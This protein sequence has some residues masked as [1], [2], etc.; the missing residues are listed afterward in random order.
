ML[1]VNIPALPASLRR[2]NERTVI[3]LLFRLGSASRA[4]LAKAAGISQ[5]TAGKII[6]DL[7]KSGILEESKGRNESLDSMNRLGRPGQ[8]LRLNTKALRFVAVELGV[9]ETLVSALPVAVSLEDRWTWRFPTPRTPD[10]WSTEFQKNARKISPE[11][12]WGVVVSVPGIVDQEKSTVLFSPNLHWLEKASV[13]AL[14]AR[15][16]D[17]PVVL[18]QEIRA[19]ALGQLTAEPGGDDFLLVDFGQGVGGAIVLGGKLYENAMPLSAEVGHTPIKG[20]ERACGCG[21]RG[22]L[23]TLASEAGLLES[24]NAAHPDHTARWPELVQ[25]LRDRGMEP[26]LKSTL[27]AA[28]RVIAGALNVLGVRRVVITGTLAEMPPEVT[29]F[30]AAAITR[31]ALWGR[32]GEVQA[33]VV[34]HRRAAGLVAAGIDRLLL[35]EMEEPA[36]AGKTQTRNT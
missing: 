31:G 6:A 11:G 20:N 5:P 7:L 2:T 18:V 27:E 13:P 33:T 1:G 23:E 26:W 14:V 25:A 10:L 3:S 9:S 24:H 30:L 15:S 28:A 17:L 32:F 12:L 22:C 29:R 4:G 35:P 34:P 19:L 21:A 8:L 36:R 16:Y